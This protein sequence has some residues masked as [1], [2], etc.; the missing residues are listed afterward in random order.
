MV[1][2]PT[3]R[4]SR[5]WG[6]TQ[7]VGARK[8]SNHGV[9]IYTTVIITG[10]EG[11][12][13]WKMS[14]EY[15]HY[16]ETHS[17]MSPLMAVAAY[18]IL[19]WCMTCDLGAGQALSACMLR[20]HNTFTILFTSPQPVNSSYTGIS[21]SPPSLTPGTQRPLSSPL[22]LSPFPNYFSASLTFS[23][24]CVYISWDT[25]SLL[26]QAI[27][28]NAYQRTHGKKKKTGVIANGVRTSPPRPPTNL[29][30]LYAGRNKQ[31]ASPLQ[32]PSESCE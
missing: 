30:A 6:R 16:Y 5:T 20:I 14:G 10:I 25:L 31:H 3:S 23:P 8:W 4:Y 15:T 13:Q 2:N 17:P 27:T 11:L 18:L 9:N 1:A 22:I 29:D 24:Q 32:S 21:L 7:E 12:F 28:A 26:G 19:A